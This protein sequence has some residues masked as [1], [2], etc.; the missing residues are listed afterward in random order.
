MDESPAAAQGV[1][2]RSQFSLLRQRRFAPFFVAQL[3]GAFNDN[4]Y[5]QILVLL[6]SFHAAEYGNLPAGLM[7]SAA[8]GIFILPY[9]IFSALAGQLS[10]RYDKS[11]VIRAV[12]LAEIFIMALAG[13]GL[14]WHSV[15]LLMLVLFLM[16]CHSAFFSPAKYS[17]LPRVL[18]ADELVGG[19]GLLEMGTFVSIILGSLLAGVLVA[20]TTDAVPLTAALLGVAVTGWLASRQVPAQSPADPHLDLSFHPWRP[21]AVMLRQAMQHSQMAAT[22]LAI[23]WFW[24][25]G[26]V[27][28]AQLPALVKLHWQGSETTVSLALGLFAV[29]V[30]TGSLSCERLSGHR[31]DLGLVVLGALGMSLFGL[32]FSWITLHSGT[33]VAF[34]A[35]RDCLANPAAWRPLADVF[36]LGASG[37]IFSV[38]L[39]AYLQVTAT[40]GEQSR[41][42]AANNVL[43]AGFMVASAVFGV[44]MA[45]AGTAPAGIVGACA[46]LNLLVLALLCW[47]RPAFASAFVAWLRRQ[48]AVRA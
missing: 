6:I 12:K 39:Y 32:D 5:K 26:A 40:P 13:A 31:V 30:G 20:G 23:S 24:F 1:K 28:L 42:I 2:P 25:Y 11:R 37:G 34:G 45:A 43:N 17:Y 46:A 47:R 16:G 29:G 19:N 35:W 33:Q 48:P 38:P 22:L 36:L 18:E 21:T 44:A 8:A 3:G 41:L 9:V 7:S 4:L 10:D 14:V 27:F 15:T